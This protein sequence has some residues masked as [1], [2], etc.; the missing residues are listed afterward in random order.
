EIE[1]A[2]NVNV[3]DDIIFC[4]N[5]SLN[6][7]GTSPGGGATSM[8]S[9]VLGTNS[10]SFGDENLANTSYGTLS[11]DLYV[12][13][14]TI[15]DGACSSYD[16]LL[17]Q[18]LRPQIIDASLTDANCGNADGSIDLSLGSL[19]TS[20]IS[21]F[22]N[23]GA[24]SEDLSSLVAATYSVTLNHSEGCSVD[25]SFVLINSDGP[26]LSTNTINGLCPEVTTTLIPIVSGGLAP[27]T[28]LWEGGETTPTLDVSPTTTTAYY[29]TLTDD[30]AC[31]NV[32]TFTANV[33]SVAILSLGEDIN[34]CEAGPYNLSPTLSMENYSAFY[35]EDFET[36]LGIWTQGLNATDDEMDWTRFS[37]STGSGN[38][39]PSN[40]ADNSDWYLYTESSSNYNKSAWLSSDAI[41]FSARSHSRLRFSYH[42]Y[43]GSMGS[44]SLE[45]SIDSSN[46]SAIWSESGNQG[47]QWSEAIIDMNAYEGE[48]EVYFR[49]IGLTGSS[50]TS[51]MA[52]DQIVLEESAYDFLWST[53]QAERSISVNPGS[54]T[55]YYLD[56][57]DDNGCALVDTLR[58]IKDCYLIGDKI[59][60][61]SN[62][63]GIQD[64]TES[65]MN[66]VKVRL[67]AD[68]DLDNT[69]DGAAI[70]SLTSNSQLGEDGHFEFSNIPLGNYVLEFVPAANYQFS[71]KSVSAATLSTDS[72]AD[73]ATGYAPFSLTSNRLDLDAGLYDPSLPIVLRDF[74]AEPNE[75]TIKL[76]WITELEVNTDYFSV[77][78]SVDGQIFSPIGTVYALGNSNT[79]THYE[80]VDRNLTMLN[81]YYLYY[82]LKEQSI[83]GE[84][85][86]SPVVRAALNGMM[87]DLYVSC[88]PNPVQDQLNVAYNSLKAQSLVLSVSN[89]L[90]QVLYT[91]SLMQPNGTLSIDASDWPSSY[92][93]I[94][95]TGEDKSYTLK[96][97]KK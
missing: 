13:R 86:Y 45:A 79:P 89:S 9:L 81:S 34:G 19:N 44:M 3:G 28:F 1:A 16:E 48:N 63:N 94:R 54:S 27:Y 95:L 7:S 75:K 76:K 26:L 42:M 83:D 11:D 30:N 57:I 10:G 73:I 15:T 37:G 53:A 85:T 97:Q 91:E 60:N 58:V 68:N 24:T 18:R 71:E 88:Y 77:E 51:D 84:Y 78:R 64:G 31:S 6:L 2:P 96:V 82:R 29:L 62:T 21:Y 14:Y 72:D 56:I 41:D 90:G 74:W 38:T 52:I 22:W 49:F 20:P 87:L 43:G 92:Y 4:P 65:G 36:D 50:Y 47:D 32:D 80:F 5:Q 70:D 39:G 59:W 8:W 46:W 35:S 69:P 17:A 12:F 67:Y 61:D 23:T 93:F 66:G 55:D 33:L 40:A 25:S